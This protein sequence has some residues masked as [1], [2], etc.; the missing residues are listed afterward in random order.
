MSR[1]AQYQRLNAI[2]VLEVD[3]GQN[4][5]ETEWG[6]TNFTLLGILFSVELNK[7]CNPQIMKFSKALLYK[8]IFKYIK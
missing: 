3:V 1:L 5:W 6:S 2:N 8:H 4:T 7:N